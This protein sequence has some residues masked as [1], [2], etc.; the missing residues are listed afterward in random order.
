MAAL[1]RVGIESR[2]LN[3]IGSRPLRRSK[4][5]DVFLAGVAGN[6]NSG[7]KL[8]SVCLL[9]SLLRDDDEGVV[10]KYSIALADEECLSIVSEFV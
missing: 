9:G 6:S 7:V 8:R 3:L 5:S 2:G 1:L 4:N 10:N